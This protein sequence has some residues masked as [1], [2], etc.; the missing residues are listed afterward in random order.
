MAGTINPMV[1][2]RT[3]IPKDAPAL[4]ELARS[5]F[6]DAFGHI[7]SDADLSAFLTQTKSEAAI[8]AK[9]GDPRQM[10]RIA[11]RGGE[12]IGY[13]CLGLDYGFDFDLGERKGVELGQLYLRGNVTGSGIG[14]A[15]VHWAIGEA[16][17]LD[18]DMMVLSVWQQNFGAQRFYRR[19]GFERIADTTF[20]VGNQIDQEHLFA[21]DLRKSAPA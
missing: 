10:L 20:R 15:F 6:V 7:Y 9:I 17:L 18:Y 5:S 2:Y 1:L 12:M 16:R 4:A 11:E 3:P 8:A 13:C 21:L 14:E 19:F